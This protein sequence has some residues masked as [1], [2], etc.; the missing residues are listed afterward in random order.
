MWESKTPR[1]L[2]KRKL[3]ILRRPTKRRQGTLS[4][5]RY[6]YA[7]RTLRWIRLCDSTSRSPA[8][9]HGVA[10]FVLLGRVESRGFEMRVLNN[11][12]RA[13]ECGETHRCSA[14]QADHM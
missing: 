9:L 5:L 12:G 13:A 10:L 8:E 7:T 6:V 3:L 11:D 1:T 14:A 4:H 2:K